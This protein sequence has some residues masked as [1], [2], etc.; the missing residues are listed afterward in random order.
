M[1]VINIGIQITSNN[2]AAQGV[3]SAQTSLNGLSNSANAAS[4]AMRTLQGILIGTLLYKSADLAKTFV[5]MAGELQGLKIRLAGV[6][7][8]AQDADAVFGRLFEKFKSA[9][10]DIKEIAQGFSR[11]ASTGLELQKT[12]ALVDAVV[13]SVAAFGGGSQEMSRAFIGFAQVLGKGSLQMEELRQ[14]IGEQIPSAMQIMAN[15]GN[16]SIAKFVDQVQKGMI[17]G[18]QAVE[19]FT[20]GAKKAFGNFASGMQYTIKGSMA[21]VQSEFSMGLAKLMKDT[22]IDER[23][24]VVFNHVA[25]VIAAFM[26]NLTQAD[27]DKFWAKFEN[28]VDAVSHIIQ[29]FARV[30]S[31]ALGFADT[32]A[33]IIDSMPQAVIDW[34]FIGYLILGRRGIAIGAVLGTFVE[35]GLQAVGDFGKSMGAVNAVAT[36][37]FRTAWTVADT[38]KNNVFGDMAKGLD[39]AR[40]ALKGLDDQ[41]NTPRAVQGLSR[42]GITALTELNSFAASTKARAMGAML[43]WLDD[44]QRS[45]TKLAQLNVQLSA[46]RNRFQALNAKANKSSSEVRD[47][48]EL[49][50]GLKG[51]DA[52]ISQVRSNTGAFVSQGMRDFRDKF[53][54]VIDRTADSISSLGERLTGN[55][56]T[57]QISQI[58]KQFDGFAASLSEAK[59]KALL[60]NNSTHAEGDQLDRIASLEDLINRYRER[61]LALVER[62]HDVH[63]KEVDIAERIEQLQL[64]ETQRQLQRS[65]NP[66][67]IA[68]MFSGTSGG[69]LMEQATAGRAQMA[70]QVEQYRQ[71]IDAK[72]Q[73]W[74]TADI[75]NR[76]SIVLTIEKYQ[77]LS[78]VT[79]D[80]MNSLTAAGLGQQQMWVSIGQTIE[81]SV[82]GALKGLLSNTATLADVGRSMFQSLTG[83]AI[84]YLLQLV[85]IDIFGKASQAASLAEAT[86]M[87]ASLSAIWGPAAVSASI[88]SF[89]T[90]SAT[91]LAAYQAAMAASIIPFKDGGVPSLGDLS[92]RVVSGPTMFGMA[93][94]AG[95]EGI[96]PLTRIGGKLGVRAEGGGNHYNINI[97]AVDTQTGMEFI[98]S[99]IEH[100]DAHLKRKSR[101]NQ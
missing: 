81:Q 34:G 87:S 65:S 96:F 75:N 29:A 90:A 22:D 38:G 79:S 36:N 8:S 77:E 76:D 47:L 99:N 50:E 64:A 23:I 66:S 63:I 2:Q 12:E 91:G 24:A 93:G 33:K 57:S 83:A 56:F 52:L 19:L 98:A 3:R 18:E 69:G 78:A 42:S 31:V 59:E 7:G 94:E 9:P 85:E 4:R 97:N 32:I 35:Q 6:T 84:D 5:E 55:E 101:L 43:P 10:F 60:L 86:A 39:K 20:N 14:Q 92:G 26:K 25:D 37:K 1:P 62:Q 40:T 82:G 13:N 89:G 21:R 95:E 28:G 71:A 11:V 80:A 68:N 67:A 44:A 53:T 70:Q 72:R 48:K 61:S 54:D 15:E 73:E 30:G 49:G 27:I 41:I 74:M 45:E 58:N 46:D 17:S 51:A 16:M 88:A 100:I